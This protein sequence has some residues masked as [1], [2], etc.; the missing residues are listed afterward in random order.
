MAD[1]VMADLVFDIAPSTQDSGRMGLLQ[2]PDS[3]SW[4]GQFEV[5]WSSEKSIRQTVG[6]RQTSQVRPVAPCIPTPLVVQA[7]KPIRH[8]PLLLEMQQA[9]K[10]CACRLHTGAAGSGLA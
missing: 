10:A 2:P 8:P 4:R 1:L 7:S 5:V 3:S 9:P 6:S